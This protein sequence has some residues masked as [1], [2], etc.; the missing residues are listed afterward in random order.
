LLGENEKVA[1]EEPAA[2]AMPVTARAAPAVA[3]TRTM[4]DRL[5]IGV[6]RFV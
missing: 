1:L 5:R 2:S 4:A 3:R 6:R